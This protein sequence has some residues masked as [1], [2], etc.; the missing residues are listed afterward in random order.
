MPEGS[1]LRSKKAFEGG[2][3]VP[4]ERLYRVVDA[5]E[6]ISQETGKTIPQVALNWLLCR[7]TVASL[8]IGARN[9]EQL[10]ENIDAV[11]WQLSPEQVARLD[12]ASKEPKIYPYWHQDGFERNPFPAG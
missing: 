12:H 4:E 8:I 3:L 9:E 7:P 2:P 6:T 10:K 5:L 11:G 1:R